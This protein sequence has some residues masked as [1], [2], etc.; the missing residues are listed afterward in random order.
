MPGLWVSGQD[1]A[2]SGFAGAMLGG[3]LAA[4]S[5]LG[6]GVFELSICGTN[7]IRDLENMGDTTRHVA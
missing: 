2:T 5:V 6:Y 1:V 3:L 7:M 4:H